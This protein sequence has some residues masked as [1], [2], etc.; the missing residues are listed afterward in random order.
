MLQL[1]ITSLEWPLVTIITSVQVAITPPR[2][3]QS[4][5]CA[6]IPPLLERLAVPFQ[7]PNRRHSLHLSRRVNHHHSHQGNRPVLQSHLV[8]PV[9]ILRTDLV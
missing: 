9:P 5:A 1:D 8:V 4:A 2:L 6:R 7:L 3:H